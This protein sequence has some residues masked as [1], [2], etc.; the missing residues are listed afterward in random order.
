[1]FLH[2]YYLGLVI[3]LTKGGDNDNEDVVYVD[4]NSNDDDAYNDNDDDG[5]DYDDDDYDD[6]D[7]TLYVLFRFGY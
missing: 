2:M 4:D 7:A 3:R 6:D 5:D 1:M